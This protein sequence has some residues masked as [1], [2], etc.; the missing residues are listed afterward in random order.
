MDN[1]QA[2]AVVPFPWQTR[3]CAG[4]IA[5]WWRID[6][7]TGRAT[8]RWMMV[9]VRSVRQSYD[10]EPVRSIREVQFRLPKLQC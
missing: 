10:A 5:L 6:Q 8:A 2:A 1:G 9:P 3:L 4:R 7:A